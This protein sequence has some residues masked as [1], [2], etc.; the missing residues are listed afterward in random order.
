MARAPIVATFVGIVIR[1]HY[2]EHEPRH[3][4][5]E[6]QAQSGKVDFVGNQ[7]VGNIT[8]RNALQL[9]RKW[10]V[11]DR[12]ALDTNWSKIKASESLNRVPPLE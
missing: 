4:H 3:F 10:A 2:R 7:T 8:S 5:A 6:F 9:I 11:L 12:A 1:M